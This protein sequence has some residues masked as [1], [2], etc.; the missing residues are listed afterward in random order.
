MMDKSTTEKFNRDVKEAIK[1]DH[2]SQREYAKKLL[3]TESTFSNYINGKR[4]LSFDFLTKLA[5]DLNLDLNHIFKS[6]STKLYA[7]SKEELDLHKALK[8]LPDKKRSALYADIMNIIDL[9]KN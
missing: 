5:T 8:A 7:L 1:R 4:G 6:D 2:K 9:I 3:L